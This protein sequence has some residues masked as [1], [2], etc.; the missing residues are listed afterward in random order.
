MVR[1]EDQL[2]FLGIKNIFVGP[3]GC[4][5]SFRNTDRDDQSHKMFG[6]GF[7]LKPNGKEERIGQT[8]QD[9]F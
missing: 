4:A 5:F 1:D 3:C 9:F 2:E 7:V 8:E 6:D